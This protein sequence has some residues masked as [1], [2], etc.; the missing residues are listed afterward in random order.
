MI[1]L[2][3]IFLLHFGF[4]S[5]ASQC[6]TMPSSSPLLQL[7]DA[8]ISQDDLRIQLSMN[9]VRGMLPPFVVLPDVSTTHLA[10]IVRSLL[11]NYPNLA[12]TASL[13]DGS[14]PLHFAASLGSVGVASALFS[15]VRPINESFLLS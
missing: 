11:R 14:L 7:L 10:E 9:E 13:Q 6:S 3:I 4:I 2:V 12:S 1:G 15:V 5:T 8:V